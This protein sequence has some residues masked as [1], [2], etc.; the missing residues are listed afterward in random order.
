MMSISSPNNSKMTRSQNI[1][2]SPA[3]TIK[4]DCRRCLFIVLRRQVSF[5]FHVSTT[6]DFDT[7]FL[8]LITLPTKLMES[9]IGTT[10]ERFFKSAEPRRPSFLEKFN[11]PDPIRKHTGG[12]EELTSSSSSDSTILTEEEQKE[13]DMLLRDVIGSVKN[14]SGISGDNNRRDTRSSTTKKRKR[15]D[16]QPDI[17]IDGGGGSRKSLAGKLSFSP[18]SSSG[19]GS[20]SGSTYRSTGFHP[21]ND[22]SYST[23]GEK[24]MSS[25]LPLV[26]PLMDV[27]NYYRHIALSLDS[28]SLSCEFKLSA[29]SSSSCNCNKNSSDIPNGDIDGSYDTR[30]EQIKDGDWFSS[31]DPI[32]DKEIVSHIRHFY[33]S[34]TPFEPEKYTGCQQQQ[35]VNKDDVHSLGEISNGSKRDNTITSLIDNSTDRVGSVAFIDL[36]GAKLLIKYLDKLIIKNAVCPYVITHSKISLWFLL[37]RELVYPVIKAINKTGPCFV[38]VFIF[39]DE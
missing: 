23:A 19:D 35:H 7:P 14:T 29:I 18:S 36:V 1:F 33:V 34:E 22:S 25:C 4:N 21:D 27:L 20:G 2:I 28:S 3:Y 5:R 15:Y 30:K 6:V 17:I 16:V 24:E 39:S 11:K 26:I 10:L 37:T 13:L 32:T 12:G 8:S 31:L 9:D 38:G